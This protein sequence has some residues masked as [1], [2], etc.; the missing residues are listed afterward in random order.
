[1]LQ[2]GITGG[3]GSG[4]TTICKFLEILNYPVYYADDRAKWIMNNDSE[5]KSQLINEFGNDTYLNNELNRAYLSNTVFSDEKK[6]N[7]LNSIVH[8]LV[9]K[10]YQQW[11][12]QSESEL[13]FKEAALLFETGSF[14]NLDKIITVYAEDQIRVGR[15]LKRD[16]HRNEDQIRDIFS[17]QMSQKEKVNLAEY[18][19]ENSGYILLIPQILK[20]LSQIKE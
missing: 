1:M 12:S 6:I 19:I 3:I 14:K 4:K 18:N 16:K 8:P 7:K 2:I 20:V 17:K 13:S 9:D 5:C 15:I 10:D 11:I